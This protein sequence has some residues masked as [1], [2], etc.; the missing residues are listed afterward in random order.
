[1]VI[2]SLFKSGQL[3]S[4]LNNHPDGMII[5]NADCQI[6]YWNNKAMRI[7]GYTKNEVI[8][9]NISFIF[10]EGMGV[11]FQAIDR[12]EGITLPVKNKVGENIFIEIIST[13]RH[14]KEE[15]IVSIR[16]AT[17]RQHTI[18]R[19][20]D[21][22]EQVRQENK[23]KYNF[24]A[25]LSMDIR[26]PLNSIIGFAKALT[27]GLSGDLNDKQK[28]YASII[29]RN[30]KTLLNQLNSILDISKLE[31]GKVE[32][33]Y[34]NFDLIPSMEDVIKI[35][36]VKAEDKKLAFE[37]DIEDIVRR[38]CFTDQQMLQRLLNE[39]LDNAIKFTDIGSIKLKISHPDLEFVKYQ[40]LEIQNGHS[41]KSFL[42]FSV[43]DTGCGI[44]E[45]DLNQIF[46]EYR[47][48]S[49]ETKRHGGTGLGLAISRKILEKLNGAIWV[50]SEILQG[51]TFNFIIPIEKV[52]NK[53]EI[54]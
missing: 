50:E 45:E 11:I 29:D 37:Y 39:I 33:E 32:F 51:S 16:D 10:E 9:K 27:D 20:L 54:R 26:T 25:N 46:N 49:P 42:M 13:D 30:A 40:G 17:I 38:K 36:R 5:V 41:D 21:E 7:F 22:F 31:A 18:G 53:N 28:K 43:T 15:I 14:S 4:I 2:K 19:I 1:M 52:K 24:I 47:E 23:T 48:I 3:D 8:G 34:K 44:H 6:T 35:A 12:E